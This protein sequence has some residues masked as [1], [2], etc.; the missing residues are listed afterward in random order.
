MGLSGRDIICLSTHYWDDRWFRK[1][2]FMSRFAAA[3]R[4]LFVEPSVSMAR[5]PETFLRELATNRH[6]RTSVERREETLYLLKPP[7]GLPKWSH[8]A[9]ERANYRWFGRLIA[10]TAAGLGFVDPIVWIYRPSFLYGLDAIHH[11]HL[12]FDLVDDLAAYDAAHAERVDELVKALASRSDLLV[13]TAKPLLDRYGGRAGHTAYV[14]NGFDPRLFSAAVDSS[15]PPDALR[16]LPRPI[17]GYI[18]ALFLF[19]DFDLLD[20]LARSHPDKSFVF[21]GPIEAT[22]AYQVERLTR[23]PNVVHI[24]TQPKS[25]VPAYLAAFDVCLSPFQKGQVADSVSPLKVYEYLAMG[26]PVVSA[27]MAALREDD[28]GNAVVFADGPQEFGRAINYCL[29]AD[30]Q[31]ASNERRR[32]VAPYAW[33]QLFDRL[34]S[35]CEEALGPS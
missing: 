26:R 2:E 1:Q 16:N 12:V 30:V 31:A 33:D 24:E 17:I 34:D 10:R 9:I 35:A 25:S 6:L 11:K 22:A 4:V 28:A 23:H 7:R 14:P 13:A 32:A 29:R 15:Q 27:P 5:K 18:G 20:E 8:P 3:N 19:L 21:L